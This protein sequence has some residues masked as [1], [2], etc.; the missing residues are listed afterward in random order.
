M[1]QLTIRGLRLRLGVTQKEA[2]RHISTQKATISKWERGEAIPRYMYSIESLLR[3]YGVH[4]SRYDILQLQKA[5]DRGIDLR[6]IKFKVG[7]E[8]WPEKTKHTA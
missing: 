8:I 6:R 3:Y 2:A 4:L 1:Q 5:F 7:D